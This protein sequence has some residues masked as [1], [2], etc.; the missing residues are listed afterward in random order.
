[1]ENRELVEPSLQKDYLSDVRDAIKVL[2]PEHPALRIVDFDK[3]TWTEI[4][5]HK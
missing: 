5:N 2:D 3:Q 1:M 4:N